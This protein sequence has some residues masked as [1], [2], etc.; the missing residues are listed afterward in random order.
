[1][2]YQAAEVID[3]AASN[4]ILCLRLWANDVVTSQKFSSNWGSSQPQDL[5][6]CEETKN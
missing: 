2:P 6:S 5:G 1:M 4:D 3:P